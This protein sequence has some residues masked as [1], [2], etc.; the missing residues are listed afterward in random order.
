MHM[1]SGSNGGLYG[2]LQLFSHSA[3]LFHYRMGCHSQ[4]MFFPST[5]IHLIEQCGFDAA[6]YNTHS[7]RIGAA[8]LQPEQA[9]LQTLFRSWSDGEAQHTRHTLVTPWLTHQTPE[10]W[11]LPSNLC[12]LV[13]TRPCLTD[14]MYS[15]KSE[16]ISKSP[17]ILGVI[18]WA[19]PV[20]IIPW[21]SHQTMTSILVWD[22]GRPNGDQCHPLVP[23]GSA[24]QGTAAT[25]LTVA[26]ACPHDGPNS[27]TSLS[28]Q[29]GNAQGVD[30]DTSAC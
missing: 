30:I 5:I 25:C 7:L 12:P 14:V 29:I 2:M 17:I 20:G 21:D 26:V 11:L 1:S 3:P 23:A 27:T 18:T 6:K 13:C 4:P 16:T 8:A 15:H 28:M 19:T 22:T 10:P 24:V 9:S